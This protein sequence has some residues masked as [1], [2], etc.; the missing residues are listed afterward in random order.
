LS[1]EVQNKSKKDSF[2]RVVKAGG[3]EI[4]NEKD[5]NA[6]HIVDKKTKFEKLDGMTYIDSCYIV[7]MLLEC[8]NVSIDN[9]RL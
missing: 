3:A 5:I 8:G 2:T 1:I 7:D 4:G 9:Y 6:L